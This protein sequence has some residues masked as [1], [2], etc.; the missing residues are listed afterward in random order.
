MARIRGLSNAERL[1]SYLANVTATGAVVAAPCV[2]YRVAFTLSDSTTSGK[3]SIGDTSAA[4][5]LVKES[6]RFDL[7]VGTAGASG[8]VV[9]QHNLDFNPPLAIGTQLFWAVSTGIASVSVSY[10]PAS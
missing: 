1:A 10:I 5:D 2:V 3:L 6:T 4:A 8:N 7:K 9:N